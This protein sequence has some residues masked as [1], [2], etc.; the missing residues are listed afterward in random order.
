MLMVMLMTV[1]A[2]SQL[3]EEALNT[4]RGLGL[5]FGN[6]ADGEGIDL[7]LATVGKLSPEALLVRVDTFLRVV[8][9]LG[10]W[11]KKPDCP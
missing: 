1:P 2:K 3:S 4:L 5:N 9:D 7:T 11:M 10:G 8:E 6:L